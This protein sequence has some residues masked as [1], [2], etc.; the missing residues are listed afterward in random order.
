[1]NPVF[2]FLNAQRLLHSAHASQRQIA[3]RFATLL[4]RNIRALPHGQT[5]PRVQPALRISTMPAVYY[6]EI[7]GPEN[8]FVIVSDSSLSLNSLVKTLDIPST[9]PK[10][11]LKLAA[12][13]KAYS[14]IL[15]G[16]WDFIDTHVK[17]LKHLENEAGESLIVKFIYD[18]KEDEETILK[19]AERGLAEPSGD[20]L[21]ALHAVAQVG[22]SRLVSP[23]LS[24]C[25]ILAKTP[26]GVSPLHLAAANGHSDLVADL[27]KKG[28]DLNTPAFWCFGEGNSFRVSPLAL[29]V[30]YGHKECIDTFMTLPEKH[31]LSLDVPVLGTIIHMATQFNRAR[32]LE[33]LLSYDEIACL[34]DSKDSFGRTALVAGCFNGSIESI[35]VLHRHGASLIIPD[36]AD[37]TSM[38]WAVKGRHPE[39]ARFLA[40]HKPGLLKTDNNQGLDPVALAREIE[41]DSL[42]LTTLENLRAESNRSE[43]RPPDFS[44]RPPENLVFTGGGPAG[45]AYLG[46]YQQLKAEKRLGD[47][48]RLAGTSAGAIASTLIALDLPED[49]LAK[50][51]EKDFREFLDYSPA[52]EQLMVKLGRESLK[53]RLSDVRS[54]LSDLVPNTLKGGFQREWKNITASI[55]T[56]HLKE[57]IRKLGEGIKIELN[58]FPLGLCMGEK[59]ERW[60]EA[61]ISHQTGISNCTFREFRNLISKNPRLKH[62]HIFATQVKREQT[63]I[64]HFTSELPQGKTPSPWDDV[65]ISSAIRGSVSIPIIFEPHRL[66][67]KLSNGAAQKAE[68]FG[69]FLD[70]GMVMNFPLEA[71]DAMHYQASRPTGEDGHRQLTNKQTLG[72]TLSQKYS[73]PGQLES[74]PDLVHGIFDIYWSAENLMRAKID[75]NHHRVITIDRQ[76]IGMLNFDLSPHQKKALIDAG[77]KGTKEFFSKKKLQK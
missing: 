71:F 3:V 75:Y 53:G 52:G 58:S 70:G 34:I 36:N 35:Q 28:A 33:H 20:N 37:D 39:V 63:E 76:N 31:S 55:L 64:A 74:F 26:E 61:I 14:N 30:A 66:S 44:F 19:L 65:I 56:F 2:P 23:L 18:N 5:C 21:T 67:I 22:L 68:E 9:T 15:R 27:V 13:N 12:F 46:V 57:A 1:M 49:E 11:L 54:I 25:K 4:P 16:D 17:E 6:K 60:I 45:L 7:I 62:I 29:A 41:R 40:Y 10:S 50:F 48:R 24:Y 43:I 72:I 73:G 47:L 77:K 51:L 8:K 42:V 59:F 38:H 32:L 69:F